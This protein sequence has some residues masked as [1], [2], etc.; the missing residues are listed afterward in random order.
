MS[1]LFNH[2]TVRAELAQ[3]CDAAGSQKAWAHANNLSPAHVNNVL[4]GRREPGESICAAL[5]F[6]RVILYEFV[7]AKLMASRANQFAT[8]DANGAR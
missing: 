7:G 4:Q 1:D 6:R 5:G 8:D 3:Q 2:S